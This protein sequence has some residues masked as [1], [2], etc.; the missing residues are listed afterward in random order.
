MPDHDVPDMLILSRYFL[1]RWERAAADISD[2]LCAIKCCIAQ[3]SSDH[4]CAAMIYKGALL[5]VLTATANAPLAAAV[6]A[7]AYTWKNVKIGGGGGF[8]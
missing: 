4:H 7:Q 2:S 6:A 1:G 3:N 5:A 8:V